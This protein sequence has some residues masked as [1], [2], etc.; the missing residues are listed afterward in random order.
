MK[1]VTE[2][3]IN[4]PDY[5]SKLEEAKTALESKLTGAIDIEERKRILQEWAQEI[6]S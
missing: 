5:E 6:L 1:D 4:E 2:K 3:L